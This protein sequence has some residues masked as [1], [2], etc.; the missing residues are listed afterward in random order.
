MNNTQVNGSA[1]SAYSMSMPVSLRQFNVPSR[2]VMSH[3]DSQQNVLLAALPRNVLDSPFVNLELVELPVGKELFG[4]GSTLTHVYFPTTAIISL[5]YVMQDG[6]TIEIAVVGRDG[7]VG[8]SLVTDERALCTAV[9]QTAGYGYRLKTQHLRNALMQGG[10]LPELLMRYT[11]TLMAQV[12]QKAVSN[13]RS[14][15][16]QRLCRWLLDRL[17]RSSTNQLK[18]THESIA[19]MLGVRRESITSAAGKLQDE[20]L[21][22]Y[23]RGNIS[24]LNRHGLELYAGDCYQV[25][26]TECRMAVS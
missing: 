8:V 6:A 3:R 12:A 7:V 22:H 11:N 21:I 18:V 1:P 2:T 20:G 9:V 25:A 4:Y 10:A 5:Q 23:R 14:S 26:K 13:R 15:I 19:V 24:V 17:D 16:E